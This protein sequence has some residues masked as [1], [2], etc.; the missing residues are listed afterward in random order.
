[1]DDSEQRL[2]GALSLSLEKVALTAQ[3][4]NEGET[5]YFRFETLNNVFP[6]ASENTAFSKAAGLTLQISLQPI[7]LWF[8]YLFLRERW[9]ERERE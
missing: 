5:L 9:K 7:L 1:M 2:V 6:F 3:W 4:K 8:I